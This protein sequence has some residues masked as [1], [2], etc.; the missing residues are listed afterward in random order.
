MATILEFETM[1]LAFDTCRE[2]NRP[3]IVKVERKLWKIYPSGA[4]FPYSARQFSSEVKRYLQ[5][6]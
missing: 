3:M 6:E 2:C 1:Q 5:G 4:A